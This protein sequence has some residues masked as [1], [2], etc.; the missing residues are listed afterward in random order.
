MK[1]VFILTFLIFCISI[2]SA[3]S[4]IGTWKT[5][6]DKTKAPKSQLNIYEQNGKLFGKVEKLL[7]PT[8]NPTKKCTDCTGSRK[9]QLI[10]GMVI[11]ENLVQKGGKWTEGTIVDPENGKSYDASIWFEG[12]GDELK[13]RGYHWTGLYRTQTW[14]RIK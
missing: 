2:F 14:Y 9:N 3:Q 12:N 10:L 7:S 8:A 4:P 13:V 5:M 11:L 1:K 6:D